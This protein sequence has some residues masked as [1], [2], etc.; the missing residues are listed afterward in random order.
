MRVLHTS[1]WHL[2][3]TLRDFSREH[4]HATFL[5]W[6]AATAR[7]RE[8][9]VLLVAGDVFDTA[10]PSAAAQELWFRFL[11]AL[12]REAPRTR[13]VVIG[14]NHD[15]AARLDA[16]SPV[17]RAL[18]V[19]VVGGLP[20]K[21]SAVETDRVIVDVTSA[22]GERAW[23]AAVPFLRLSDLAAEHALDAPERGVHAVYDEVFA[24]IRAR[25]SDGEA[26][27]AMGHLYMVE[28]RISEL[29]ERKILGGNQHALPVEIFP[30]DVAYA[31]LGHL[32]LAQAIGAREHV[33]YSGSPLPLSM[34]ES[35]YEHQ[36]VVF[37][38]AEGRLV[39]LEVLRV[40]REVDVV[41]IP[42]N[43]ALPLEAALA[44]LRALPASSSLPTE[45]W[46][47]VEVAIELARPEPTLQAQVA[48]ALEGRAARLVKNTRVLPAD[49]PARAPLDVRALADFT[50]EQVFRALWDKRQFGGAPPDDLLAT[51]HE[52]AGEAEATR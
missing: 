26:I 36:V 33:R 43:G 51:F 19:R 1:D 40:P 22:T 49:A 24:A 32:H 29:S 13:V 9:D 27:L 11:A 39:D 30:E 5:A 21:G 18:D 31:A 28:G 12:R 16:P 14:G 52:L 38:L 4:E 7:E 17:L 45:R 37:E 50:P 48:D 8:V 35:H 6:L 42:A 41:R 25:R 20:R 23:I 44:K 34:T 46:P 2:G 3:H 47:F 10:N 15:S